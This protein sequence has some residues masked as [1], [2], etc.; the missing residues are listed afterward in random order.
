MCSHPFFIYYSHLLLLMAFNVPLCLFWSTQ[1]SQPNNNIW[2]LSFVELSYL[3]WICLFFFKLIPDTFI[4]LKYAQ[5]IYFKT[6]KYIS[7]LI[8]CLFYRHIV[9]DQAGFVFWFW[10]VMLILTF[11]WKPRSCILNFISYFVEM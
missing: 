3:S 1:F 8:P 11:F 9:L 5:F 4:R 2:R 10:Q 7:F 6:Y